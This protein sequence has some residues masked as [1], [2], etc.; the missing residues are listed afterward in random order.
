MQILDFYICDT[1]GFLQVM[2]LIKTLLNILRFVVP[3]IVIVMLVMDLV[4]NVINPNE[5]EGM[6]K[7][8]TRIAAAVI[9]FL[10]PTIINLIVHL[11]N[12]IFEDNMD[13]DYTN[14]TCYTNANSE[15][16]KNIEDYLNCT[17]V[18]GEDRKNCLTYRQCNNY[19]LSSNCS[20]TTE[21]NDDCNKYNTDSNYAKFRK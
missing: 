11:I 14:S 19:K 17:D 18:S 3:I 1:L 15:C 9:V 13:T 10:I 2:N 7:I 4:K 20:L 12:I 21:L 8:V 5:K 16:I 6:K